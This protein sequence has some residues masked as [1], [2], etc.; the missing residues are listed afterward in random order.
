MKSSYLV[1]NLT[2][3]LL[4]LTF[5]A[6]ACKKNSTS[7]DDG[8]TIVESN[9]KQTPTTD[10]TQL[11]NDSLFLYAKQIYYWNDVLPAYDTFNP[12]Q[13]GAD[14]NQELF[15]ITQFKINPTTGKPYEYVS[16]EPGYTDGTKYS[17]IQDITQNNPQTIASVPGAKNAVDLEGIGNDIGIRPISYITNNNYNGTF[18]LYITAVYPNSPADKAGVK[19][20]WLIK[21]IN[22]TPVGTNYAAQQSFLSSSLAGSEVS[23]TGTK[24]SGGQAGE[25]FSVTLKSAAYTSNPIYLKKVLTVGAKKIGY[26]ALARFSNESNAV[27]VLDNAFSDFT[28]QGVTDLVIDLRYNGGGYV[29]TAE[30]LVNLIA[31]STA[32]GTMFIE[33]YN[34][35]MQVGRKT[36]DDF[37][38]LKNQPRTDDSGKIVGTYDDY[39]YSPAGNTATFS[40]AGSLK[41]VQNIVFLVSRS[42]ASASELVINSLKP[43]MNVKLVGDTTYGKPVGFFP[44]RLEN[45]YDVYL[46]SFET[47]N[48]AGQGGY[49]SGMVPDVNENSNSSDFFDDPRFDF[50]ELKENYLAKAISLLAPGI[51]TTGSTRSAVMSI[52]G[53][54][55]PVSQIQKLKPLE[56][57]DGFNGMIENRRRLKIK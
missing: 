31:P 48:S 7:D 9:K 52:G 44:V 36:K 3:G 12:R 47:K 19:R 20:G 16:P 22:K 39:D 5:F 26:L 1:K 28:N 24:Y 34:A 57:T 38:I 6:S 35:K 29:S 14:Y 23:L 50:G 37:T 54:S 27:T 40:K 11:T 55:I 17:Y 25:S 42:T 13:Y 8:T 41:T 21:T 15:T 4:I 43:H 30:H 56:R 10:R 18:S 53:K 33:Y 2:F 49:Y 46:A 32:T 45:R 51:S